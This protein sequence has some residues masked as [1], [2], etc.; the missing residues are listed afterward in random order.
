M[1]LF[2]LFPFKREK[3]IYIRTV[4]SFDSSSSTGSDAWYEVGRLIATC[5]DATLL[6]RETLYGRV[7]PRLTF[8]HLSPGSSGIDMPIKQHLGAENART[9]RAFA[10][11]MLILVL[12]TLETT[13]GYLLISNRWYNIP[14]WKI[15]RHTSSKRLLLRGNRMTDWIIL[16]EYL[17]IYFQYFGAKS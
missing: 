11:G 14:S 5:V 2:K 7:S 13:D 17:V 16:I 8:A 9:P 12:P 1:R 6:T 4:P 10:P 3:K 15:L